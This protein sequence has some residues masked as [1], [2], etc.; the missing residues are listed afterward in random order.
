MRRI[1]MFL[2]LAVL[3]VLLNGCGGAN[4]TGIAKKTDVKNTFNITLEEGNEGDVTISPDMK[5]ASKQGDLGQ[6][7]KNNSSVDPRTSA[8][9]SDAAGLANAA[10]DKASNDIKDATMRVKHQSSVDNSNIHNSSAAPE[11]PDTP[12]GEHDPAMPTIGD[13]IYPKRYHHTLVGG[14]DGGISFKACPGQI[15]DYVKCSCEGID[16][17]RHNWVK[18]GTAPADNRQGWWRTKIEP[19]YNTDII[20]TTKTGVEHHYKIDKKE[21]VLRGNCK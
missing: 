14:T 3:T 1:L 9:F 19:K 20:C 7:T 11:N 17:P 10:L 8:A 2:I 15:L 4:T 13:K 18:D 21:V 5:Y 6:E 16:M 12:G